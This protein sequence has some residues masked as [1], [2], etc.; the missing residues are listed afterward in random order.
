MKGDFARAVGPLSAGSPVYVER[1]ADRQVLRHLLRMEYV[2]IT[3]PRQ[4]GKTSLLCQLRRLL[5]AEYRVAYVDIESLAT[6]SEAEWYAALTGR[7]EHQ[8]PDLLDWKAA[9]RPVGAAT[10]RDLLLALVTAQHDGGGR[11]VVIALDEMGALDE[12]WA[13]AFFRVLRE[14]FTVREFQND[15]RRLSFLLVG[16]FDPSR[17]IKDPDISPFNVAQPV[18]LEDFSAAQVGELAARIGLGSESRGLVE[19][20]YEWT[21]GHPFLAHNLSLYLAA[22]ESGRE[23]E[24]VVLAA[25]DWMLQTDVAHFRGIRRLLEAEPDLI[26]CARRL[27]ARRGKLSP[28]LNP[29][30]FQLAHV[31]G[32]VKPDSGGRCLVRNRV[33]ERG[34]EE[35]LGGEEN[36]REG[37]RPRLPAPVPSDGRRP[38]VISLHGIRTRGTWQKELTEELQVGGID[39]VPLDYGFF[40][41]LQLLLP[42]SRRRKVLW[43]RDEYTRCVERHAGVRPSVI[44]H[45]FGSYLVARALEMFDEVRFD[46]IIL[47]GSIVRRDYPWSRVIGSQ[48]RRALHEFGH[49]DLWA[50]VVGLVVEDAGP[51]GCRGFL[52]LAEGGVIQRCHPEFRHSDYFY[53]LNY[54]HN[55]VPF[56]QGGAPGGDQLPSAR[57]SNWWFRAVLLLG[58]TVVVLLAARLLLG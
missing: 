54:R 16:A 44:A 45:S 17:L 21:G 43:F 23:N 5:P 42:W 46:E 57:G 19:Q 33:Y 29:Q 56:L 50:R 35:L 24:G 38:L 6:R 28:G 4:Q 22:A 9:P 41:A 48:A 27:I 12:P 25:V 30:H 36:P 39:H 10:W 11:R 40:M 18:H 2:Q 53:R 8:L 55:W 31:I 58:A 3:D 47:C 1:E 37:P 14:A 32:V 26:T 15:F 51:S 7:L 52:D 13:E 49:Q 20:L 34:M